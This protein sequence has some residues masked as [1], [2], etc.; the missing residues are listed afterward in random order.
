MIIPIRRATVKILPFAKWVAYPFFM[1]T[2]D[3]KVLRAFKNQKTGIVI[4]LIING[5]TIGIEAIKA[6]IPKNASVNTLRI[7]A[8]KMIIFSLTPKYNAEIVADEK[9]TQKII[10]L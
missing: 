7:N 2:A 8:E 9:I 3:I 4:I 6:P 5:P 10:F 1:A